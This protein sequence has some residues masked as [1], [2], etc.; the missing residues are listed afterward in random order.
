M[1]SLSLVLAMVGQLW[2]VL[3]VVPAS[4]FACWYLGPRQKFCQIF[5]FGQVNRG[6]MIRVNWDMASR[7]W[8][9]TS[10]H[11]AL[12]AVLVFT[13]ALL[14]VTDTDYVKWEKIMIIWSQNDVQPTEPANLSSFWFWPKNP[15][16]TSSRGTKTGI[17]TEMSF[18]V[19]MVPYVLRNDL[20]F[21]QDSAPCLTATV[22][23]EYWG[24]F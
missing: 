24:N 15:T 2:P 18:R 14:V 6:C 19:L 11:S 20:V 17:T 9:P 22:C 7:C 5:F 13:G 16:Y 8:W 12:Q 21:L 1:L 23:T 10:C 3:F 4:S